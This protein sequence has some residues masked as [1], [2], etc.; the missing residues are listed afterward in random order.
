MV[1]IDTLADQEEEV[2]KEDDGE[3]TEAEPQPKEEKK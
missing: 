1:T 3:S 2:V